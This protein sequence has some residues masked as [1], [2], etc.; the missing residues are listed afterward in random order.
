[1]RDES[2]WGKAASEARTMSED[3]IKSMGDGVA[4]GV[5]KVKQTCKECSP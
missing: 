4:A 5:G 1:L 2:A 3:V